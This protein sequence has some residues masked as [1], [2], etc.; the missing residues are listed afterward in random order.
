MF[1]SKRSI[2]YLPIL[3]EQETEQ[4]RFKIRYT[5]LALELASH[6]LSMLDPFSRYLF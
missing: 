4:P 3:A 2:P 1:P 5:S 6:L